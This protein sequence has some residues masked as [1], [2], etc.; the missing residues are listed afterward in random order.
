MRWAYLLFWYHFLFFCGNLKLKELI[1]LQ[2]LGGGIFKVLWAGFIIWLVT[3]LAETRRVPFDFSEGESELVSGFNVEYGA[4]G[5]ALIF[6]AEYGNIIF[7]MCLTSWIFF[8]GV[9]MACYKV[10]GLLYFILWVRGT[11][12][13]FRYDILIVLFWKGILPFSLFLMLGI[14]DINIICMV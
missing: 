2:G 7:M 11:L 13:R 12:V 10:L 14:V 3:I 5:F 9:G 1:I 4:G 6:I 8:A